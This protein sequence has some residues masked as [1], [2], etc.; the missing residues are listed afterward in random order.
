MNDNYLNKTLTLS[1]NEK[2]YICDE[3]NQNGDIYYLAVKLDE[4]NEVGDESKIYKRAQKD[5]RVFL[6]DKIDENTFKYLTA[7]FI[8]DLNNNYDK[9]LSDLNNEEV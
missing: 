7:I 1:N 9:V 6:D 5:N 3:T 4:N 8:T 2:W